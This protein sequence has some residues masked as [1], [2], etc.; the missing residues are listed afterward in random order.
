MVCAESQTTSTWR[1][2]VTRMSGSILHRRCEDID[3]A[4]PEREPEWFTS[5]AELRGRY[6]NR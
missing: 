1:R 6:F 3:S 2:V 4:C 5:P